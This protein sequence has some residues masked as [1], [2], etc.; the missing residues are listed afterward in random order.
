MKYAAQTNSIVFIMIVSGVQFIFAQQ[1]IQPILNQVKYAGHS[2]NEISMQKASSN[3]TDYKIRI[4]QYF[5]SRDKR[6][7][8]LSSIQIHTP[9]ISMVSDTLYIGITGKDTVISGTVNHSG[10]ICI[11]ANKLTIRNANLNNTGNIIII[12]GQLEI[13][14]STV[15]NQGYIYVL[16]TG[17]MTI[18]S[19]QV[20]NN[21]DLYIFGTARV[22]V[23]YT[24][25]IFPQT[26]FYQ[27]SVIMGGAA[28]LAMNNTT[29]NYDSKSGQELSHGFTVTDSA[30]LVESNMTLH[31]F[32]TTGLSS[33][34][35]ISIIGTTQAGEFIIDDYSNLNIKN[36]DTVLLWHQ[37]PDSAVINWNFGQSDTVYH[38]QFNKSKAGV[39]G[40]EYNIQVDSSYIVWWAMMPSSG[41]N[42]TLSD[43]KIRAIG[44]WFDKGNDSLGVSGIHD[45]TNYS[46]GQA[47]GLTD[48]N[49]VL[50]NC[51][52]QTWSFYT[53]KNEKLSIAN[54]QVGEIGSEDASAVYGNNY[55][56]DGTG[57][58]HW[59]TD[60]AIAFA[61][62]L[63]DYSWARS[64]AS[65][66]FVIGYSA[67]ENAE[68]IDSSILIV[69]QSDVANGPLA[70]DGGVAW[71]AN[72]SNPGTVHANSNAGIYGSAWIT[73]GPT[74]KQMGFKYWSLYYQ[75]QGVSAVSW[76]PI[77]VENITQ[78][79]SNLLVT[80]NTN[81]LE[82]GT[83]IL[84]LNLK[85][86]YNDS[87]DAYLPVTVTTSTGI[88]EAI[89]FTDL[90]IFPNPCLGNFNLNFTTGTAEKIKIIL[91]DITGKEELISEDHTCTTGNNTIQLNTS[92]LS[93]GVYVCRIIGDVHCTQRLIELEKK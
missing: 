14:T 44:L 82:A 46:F 59:T 64:E 71:Y 39:K 15:N 23:N 41:S 4:A 74:S 1:N 68:A 10:P 86:T 83:Y 9:K 32:T 2:V 73:R 57:G 91:S 80:W 30:K 8:R 19:S 24:T 37:F 52:V 63:I 5:K 43:S 87:V 66:V 67:L 55:T 17:Q 75:Q 79:Q 11:L 78:V 7:S 89:D 56:V 92:G 22:Y 69:V 76:T 20:T 81:G 34:A 85:S 45:S 38:Y 40:I 21:G 36:A 70:A 84:R 27:L 25:L 49:L 35:S 88:P 90:N 58:Y 18:N 42:V 6:M 51:Y 31:G 48:R 13:D 16:E 28:Q 61:N 62:N 53:F 72:I 29:L 12:G 93:S 47:G 26:Y 54:C 3:N 33:K 50:N 60:S 65:S 77:T